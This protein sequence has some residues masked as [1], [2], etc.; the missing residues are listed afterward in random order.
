MELDKWLNQEELFT[1]SEYST[2]ELISDQLA[3]YEEQT[4]VG[5]YGLVL[6]AMPALNMVD[7]ERYKQLQTT[8]DLLVDYY[9]K[10]SVDPDRASILTEIGRE[11]M[12]ILRAADHKIK[13]DKEPFG[14][15][16]DTLTRLEQSFGDGLDK[17]PDT[18]GLLLRSNEEESGYFDH[19]EELFD[20]V[21]TKV[22]LTEDDSLA[23]QALM[24][25]GGHQLATQAIVG[26]LFVGAMEFFDLRKLR[27]LLMT[28]EESPHERTIGAALVAL[29]ML[30]RRHQD[31]LEALHSDFIGQVT[32][33][34]LQRSMDTDERQLLLAIRTIYTA[35]QTTSLH[36]LFKERVLPELAN[37]S[38]RMQQLLNSGT[39]DL[40]Q[41]MQELSHEE[42][43]EMYEISGLME[44]TQRDFQNII[45]QDSD[46]AFHMTAQMKVHPFFNKVSHWFLPYS[47]HHPSVDRDAATSLEELIPVLFQGHVPCSS[48]LYSFAVLDSFGMIRQQIQQQL[49]G[50]PLPEPAVSNKSSLEQG[51]RD[52]A[53][54]A[55]RFYTLSMLAGE[56]VN[57]FEDEPMVMD[58]PFTRDQL[59]F[60]EDD[61]EELVGF[62]KQIRFYLHTE[63]LYLR[64]YRFY[65]HSSADLWR[66][67]S[68]TRLI[69]K[70]DEL[71]L[72]LLLRAV[73][74]EG[75]TPITAKKIGELKIDLEGVESVLEW[76][77]R[78]EA[79][80][81]SQDQLELVQQRALLL[82]EQ[83]EYE[84]ALSAVHKA[85][86]LG[87]GAEVSETGATMLLMAKILLHLMRPEEAKRQLDHFAEKYGA[88]EGDL[89][90][91]SGVIRMA[92]G[93]ST[94]EAVRQMRQTIKEGRVRED[95]ESLISLLSI[96]DFAPWELALLTDLVYAEDTE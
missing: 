85:L 14:V 37:L 50:M 27:L 51:M 59:L 47:K 16:Y 52:F 71:A 80:L 1:E 25:N 24:T 53:F 12:R 19:L 49:D 6:E 22:E 62:L 68:A 91:V 94:Q 70:D 60:A 20:L 78:C 13:L 87:E 43:E 5:H 2:E 48:D 67:L 89:S 44:S 17:I 58:G 66:S 83:Q 9:L 81:P 21:W 23:L 34:L 61:L 93:Q 72:E 90:L 15:R 35:Y 73:E 92:M 8:Y 26:A 86:Y 82:Y 56:L 29:L 95:V 7:K 88:L 41:R 79:S 45:S 75:I 3:W 40:A 4:R 30:G 69:L 38:Q 54:G 96:Y 42:S 28:L 77:E 32:N 10:G 31:E 64:L 84:P 57:P 36:Q 39:G 76:I 33:H 74:V 46:V 63:G 65:D 18:I 55:Y 11:I